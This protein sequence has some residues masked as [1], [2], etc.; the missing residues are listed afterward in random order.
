MGF[1]VL[2]TIGH[3]HAA[4]AVAGAFVLFAAAPISGGLLALRH[5]RRDARSLPSGD[6][7]PPQLSDAG[8]EIELRRL[9]E[10]RQG[11]LTVDEVVLATG[12][13]PARVEGLLD[14]LCKKGVAEYRVADEGVIVYRLQPTLGPAAKAKARGLLE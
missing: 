2:S 12:L 8:W 4:A 9:G 6:R 1:G 13:E 3:G 7:S 5:A 11:N 10:R 14:A